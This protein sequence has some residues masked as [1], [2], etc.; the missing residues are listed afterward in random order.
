VVP[1][2]EEPS[3]ELTDAGIPGRT[4]PLFEEL[5]PG[6]PTWP[7][8]MA[9]AIGFFVALFGLA[10][11]YAFGAGQLPAGSGLAVALAGLAGGALLLGG[12]VWIAVAALIRR[13][14]LP[15]SRYR[16]PSIFV[17]L[18]I[19]VVAG[20]LFGT[21]LIVL[22]LNGNPDRLTSPG[23]VTVLLF[24][25]PVSFLLVTW[26]FAGLPRVLPG[27]RL[28]RGAR[29]WLDLGGGLLLGILAA[30]AAN[31]LVV[32]IAE[33]GKAITGQQIGGEQLVVQLA[34]EVP[35][36]AAIGALVVAAPV[37]EE[38]FF[39]GLALNAW[40]R[41]Y[42][43]RRAVIGSALLFAAAHLLDGSYLA[44]LPILLL[45]LLLAILFVRQRSLA[46]TIGVHAGFNL[47]SAVALLLAH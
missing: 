28:F 16:G 39:R 37:A 5:P 22:M 18:A 8:W 13:R 15:A 38:L 36:L 30:F 6:P 25:T 45:G 40:E 23:V 31:L 21:P 2:A 46:L 34:Q 14:P 9:V 33:L 10:G 7:A 12:L 27:L 24:L 35:P 29:S 11:I 20:N 4:R 1:L 41:E 44:F 3:R 43:T 42:G 47:V 26:I 19:V 32:L 17:L